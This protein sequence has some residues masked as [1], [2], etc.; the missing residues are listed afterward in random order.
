MISDREVY[1]TQHLGRRRTLKAKRAKQTGR[2]RTGSKKAKVVGC[3]TKAG[4]KSSK[5]QRVANCEGDISQT[6]NTAIAPFA[7][8]IL[9]SL[10]ST[11]CV[12]G[13]RVFNI[14]VE[15]Q[16]AGGVETSR[17]VPIDVVFALDSS[18]SMLDNDPN[19]IRKT[20]SMNILDTLDPAVDRAALVDW[21]SN[22]DQST[23]ALISDFGI[24]ESQ[25]A[26]VDSF[27]SD[28]GT[29]RG[30]NLNVGLAEP[31][32]LLDTVART[33]AKTIIFLTDGGM[34]GDAYTD[35]VSGGPAA[36]ASSKNYRIFAI[37]LSEDVSE[38]PLKD[39]ADCTGGIYR[40]A[41]NADDLIDLFDE[42]GVIIA[43]SAPRSISVTLVTEPGVEFVPGTQ[44]SSSP[45]ASLIQASVEDNGRSTLLWDNID[46]GSGLAEGQSISFVFGV[47]A[48]SSGQLLDIAESSLSYDNQVGGNVV[49]GVPQLSIDTDAL[50][51]PCPA[52]APGDEPNV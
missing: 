10:A 3:T 27:A 39:M 8:N 13:E 20:A 29:G 5:K 22:I 46:G 49:V 38:I 42:L 37:G 43:N 1:D 35:C 32:R 44:S 14:N 15:V 7:P 26:Q 9:T 4:K 31:I 24:V 40:C 2:K 21:D 36:E 52:P 23:G 28:D 34:E 11:E 17:G 51:G 48:S 25:I 16:G 12:D 41:E 45:E 19:G 33:S 50:G 30:T 6:M 18:G 47:K